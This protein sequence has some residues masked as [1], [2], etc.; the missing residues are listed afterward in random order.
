M[1][2]PVEQTWD[3]FISACLPLGL[4]K[5]KDMEKERGEGKK[6][7]SSGHPRHYLTLAYSQKTPCECKVEEVHLIMGGGDDILQFP[8][9]S[10]WLSQFHSL[11]PALI[12]SL[13]N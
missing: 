7:P 9:S 3:A 5:F 12:R 2:P 11:S 10:R 4:R 13:T 8:A 1:C 6:A